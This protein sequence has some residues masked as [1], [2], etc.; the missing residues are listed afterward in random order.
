[1]MRAF[2]PLS[3]GVALLLAG[4]CGPDQG[5][6]TAATT[7]RDGAGVPGVD[8]ATIPATTTRT[9]GIDEGWLEDF[10]LPVGRL[11]DVAPLSGGGAVI[12]D[13]MA[14]TLSVLDA[15]A[16]VVLTLGGPGEGPGEFSPHGGV[17]RVVVTDS[18]YL[19]P[20]IEL[21][22]ITEFSMDGAL[23]G[24]HPVPEAGFG[25]DWRSHP[26]GGIVFR[27]LDPDGDRILWSRSGGVQ[28]LHVFDLPWPGG[29][30]LLPP[31]ALWDVGGEGDLVL[32]RSDRGQVER[33]SPGTEDPRWVTRWEDA[34]GALTTRD[35]THLEDL[36]LQSAEEQGLGSLPAGERERRL[37]AVS[38]PD[39]VPVVASI[40]AGP[41]GRTWVQ[42]VRP[43]REMGH[44]A[45]QVGSATGF[46]GTEWRVLGP[47]GRLEEV[48][49]LPHGFTPRRFVGACM[50]GILEDELGVQRP[51]RVC[52]G[53]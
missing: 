33:R 3:I 6:D 5:A 14:G 30:P 2:P 34:G 18:S 8:P 45:L 46:G 27:I 41:A 32:G 44:A 13:E 16:R 29:S 40:L 25:V 22:R 23:L 28:L 36:I 53:G 19:V 51:A 7:V 1:M 10:D 24:I 50:Y 43:V 38:L 39:S 42:G 11:A 26:Q 48:V 15:R 49:T 17:S 4:G 35:R 21:Q 12:L 37:R 52:V 31:T 9:V 47:E 20:D